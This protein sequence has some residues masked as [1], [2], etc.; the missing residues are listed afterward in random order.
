LAAVKKGFGIE[1]PQG[2]NESRLVYASAPDRN[3][4]PD[5]TITN[6]K[7]TPLNFLPK[8][9]AEQFSRAMNQ[10]F[11]L[12]ACLQL[13]S[14]ITPV[15]PVSTFAPLIVI[16]AITALKELVDDRYRAAADKLAN[17]RKYKIIRGG[18]ETEVMS[19][20]IMVGDIVR[21]KDKE[22]VP[23][24]M[25][26][27]HSSSPNGICFVQTTNLDG[28]TNLKARQ[29]PNESQ[30]LSV[31][32]I[33]T[34][35]GVVECSAPD[36]FV[37]KFDARMWL[38]APAGEGH[39]DQEHAI[40]LSGAQ[41][42][43][44]TIAIKNVDYVYGVAVYT[45]NQTKFSKNKDKPPI[46]WTKADKF[47]NSISVGIFLFQLAI[48]IIFGA[49]GNLWQ[50]NNSGSA[51]YL[52]FPDNDA[53]YNALIIPARFLLLNSTMIPIS[54]KVTLDLC[55][56]FYAK[57][58]GWDSKM[59][60]DDEEPAVANNSSISEDLGQI[61]YVLSDKTGTLTQN[62]M[63]FQKASVGGIIYSMEEIKES[64][65]DAKESVEHNFHEALSDGNPGIKAL[66]LNMVLNNG[67]Q[68]TK[69]D[70]GRVIFRSASPD[71][72]ALVQAC[73]DIGVR[74]V[75]RDG[76]DIAID[77]K[78]KIMKFI[79]RQELEFTSNRKRMSVV[80]RDVDSGEMTLY[81]KGA[82]DVIYERL[83][84]DQDTRLLRDHLDV[85]AQQ[86]LRTLVY[87]ARP[88]SEDEFSSWIELYQKA[89]TE[90]HNR[91][92]AVENACEQLEKDFLLTGSTAI[93]DKLQVDVAE[94]ISVSDSI[95]SFP[96]MINYD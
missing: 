23:C 62:S 82:D 48:V 22:E 86:G 28:E 36:H 74:L 88:I 75:S 7:Y 9:L 57:F 91:E 95:I 38:E 84:N 61:Q 17:Q 76:P 96:L 55:K 1:T 18:H 72:E 58:I 92:E 15:N 27:L 33:E 2:E 90:I 67:V 30:N 89:K 41:F 44:Q 42:L 19:K 79:Q 34:F 83:R 85:F 37:Y 60:D 25:C 13:I 78:G 87:A 69:T 8:N 21:L 59:V 77:Y 39:P 40:S 20:D 12:I 65:S 66:V 31:A 93:E 14:T 4:F 45:G 81:I 5:N 51:W 56:L 32:Q 11:L 94:T 29:A 71:E 50:K 53:W 49:L 54:L 16:F 26:L 6:T 68:P 52:D 46:K 3:D 43:Q 24:D 73:A 64:S 63:A 10:Y 70:D 80:T 47:I 35:R